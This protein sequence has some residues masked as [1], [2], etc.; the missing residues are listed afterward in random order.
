MRN[1]PLLALLG[2][3]LLLAP[4]AA[5]AD[6]LFFKNG[7]RWSGSIVSLERGRIRF[8]TELVGQLEV[9][10]S[11][12]E[13]FSAD[14]PIEI[15][16]TDGTVLVD[17]VAAAEP[18]SYRT[19]GQAL[20]GEQLLQLSETTAINPVEAEWSGSLMVGADLE[21]GNTIKDSAYVQLR[22]GFQSERHRIALR[23][24]YEGERTTTRETSVDPVTGAKHTTRVS[25]TQDR[26]L[27]G[28]LKYDY[29]FSQRDFWWLGTSGEKDGPSDLDLRFIAGAGLGRDL[30]NR[31]GFKLQLYAGP[32]FISEQF[33]DDTSDNQR[34]AGTLGWEVLYEVVP[35]LDFFTEGTY[36]QAGKDDILVK[37]EVGLRHDVTQRLFLEGKI[38]WE[39]DSEPAED[40]E[41]QDVDYVLG[42][43]YKF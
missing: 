42:V 22:A 20:P 4:H 28:R 3:L 10:L 15:H 33:S 31:P 26:N 14:R 27:F 23:G 5:L 34:A 36:T 7:D 11:H 25:T 24:S 41:R 17:A 40:A 1:A 13:T 43:G 9:A 21:R 19:M 2:L 29:L 37:S 38:L 16:M 8:R 39:Y 12:V 32:T 6:E 18:G 30:Y 35:D